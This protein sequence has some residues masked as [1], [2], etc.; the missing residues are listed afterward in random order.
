MNKK[1]RLKYKGSKPPKKWNKLII[2]VTEGRETEPN[3]FND[4]KKL[5]SFAQDLTLRIHKSKQGGELLRLY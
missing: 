1:Q 2:M 5:N 3:Y 4:L